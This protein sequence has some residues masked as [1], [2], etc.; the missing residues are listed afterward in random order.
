M[1][2]G[3]QTPPPNEPLVCNGEM[4]LCGDSAAAS[5]WGFGVGAAG[6]P[7]PPPRPP[8]VPRGPLNWYRNMRPNWRWA[9]TAK[10]RKVG[11]DPA[12]PPQE[13]GEGGKGS[14]RGATAVPSPTPAPCPPPLQILM[15]ALMVTAGKDVVLHPSMSKG[16]EEWVRAGSRPTATGP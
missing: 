16:M 15:P 14:G 6:T 9:L 11:T 5:L 10:D 1:L 13:P 8:F 4:R 2:G 12:P 7:T 3:S